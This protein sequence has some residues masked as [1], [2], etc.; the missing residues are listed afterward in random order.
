MELFADED[1]CAELGHVVL[2]EEFILLE[3]DDCMAATHTDIIDAEL[4][5]VTSTNFEL[6][7]TSLG[8]QHMYHPL[9]VLLQG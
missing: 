5:V 6:F 7:G 9:R 2:Q 4:W 3:L 1:E 8:H